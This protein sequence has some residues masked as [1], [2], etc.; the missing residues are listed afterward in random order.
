[1]ENVPLPEFKYEL[2]QRDGI[3]KFHYKPP[4]TV[5][6]LTKAFPFMSAMNNSSPKLS[7][8]IM[9]DKVSSSRLESDEGNGSK[10]E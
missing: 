9:S 7:E 5:G 2:S 1:M 6:D 10:V 8:D 4:D 3:R